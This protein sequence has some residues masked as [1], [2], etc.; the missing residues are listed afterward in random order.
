MRLVADAEGEGLGVA[1]LKKL[2]EFRLISGGEKADRT[3]IVAERP[4]LPGPVEIARRYAAVVLQHQ[5]AVIEQE[6]ADV[7]KIAAVQNGAK[8]ILSRIYEY[9]A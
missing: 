2:G 8:P 4:Q 7:R 1:I 5:I 3:G 9:T 6:I